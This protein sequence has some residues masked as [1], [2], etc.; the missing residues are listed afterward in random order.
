MFEIFNYQRNRNF[1]FD[2]VYDDF[3]S[4]FAAW[5]SVGTMI[6]YSGLC[7]YGTSTSGINQLHKKVIYHM[8][9]GSS[10]IQIFRRF[11]PIVAI[12]KPEK[13]G[14]PWRDKKTHWCDDARETA[15][16]ARFMGPIWGPFGADRTELGP[17]LAPWT[18]LSG[19]EA[20]TKV[21]FQTLWGDCDSYQSMGSIWRIHL[22]MPCC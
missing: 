17:M 12:F 20:L 6:I 18:L 7:I 8:Y 16:T 9:V 2:N 14:Q 13:N 15:L 5:S 1:I 21:G 3:T 11:C 10:M 22:C 4:L 19:R